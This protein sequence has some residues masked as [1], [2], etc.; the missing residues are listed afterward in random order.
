MRIAF[1]GLLNVR[2]SRLWRSRPL[3]RGRSGNGTPPP[4][5]GGKRAQEQQPYLPD[6]FTRRFL[7]DA[8]DFGPPRS[9]ERDDRSGIGAS[10]PSKQALT[11]VGSLPIE[12]IPTGIATAG[13]GQTRLRSRLQRAAAWV[14]PSRSANE[15]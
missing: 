15:I 13:L 10:R 14:E 9:G 1:Q 8:F 7:S 6:A 12:P 4:S 2:P 3:W 5:N 11:N